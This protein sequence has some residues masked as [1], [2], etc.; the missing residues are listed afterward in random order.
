MMNFYATVTVYNYINLIRKKIIRSY[1]LN[2]LVRNLPKVV[3]ER[4]LLQMFLKFGKVKSFNIVTDQKTGVSKGFGFVDMPEQSEAEAAI[5]ALDGKFI[6]GQRIRVKNSTQSSQTLKEHKPEG[7]W[8]KHSQTREIK[9]AHI[10]RTSTGRPTGRFTEKPTGRSTGRPTGRP[11]ERPTDRTTERST[12]RSTG[13]PTGRFTDKPAGRSTGRPT[14]R[15]HE[16]PAGRTTERSIE[17]PTG[18]PARRFTEKPAERA[19][20]RR[21]G[22]TTE[23]STQRPGG[24]PSGRSN[25]RPTGRSKR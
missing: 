10:G 17:R 3:T 15:P 8:E 18:R 23:K 7:A 11:H 6:R 21:T 1:H 19:T 20:G 4:E 9:G 13:R 24:R 5:K 25:A 2:I 14:G 16:R 12:E 22:R